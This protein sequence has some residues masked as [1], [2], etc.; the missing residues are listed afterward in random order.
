[1]QITYFFDVCSV[2]CALSDEVIAEV[3]QRYGADVE[4]TWKIALINGGIG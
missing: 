1:M 2:W 3:G 4:I